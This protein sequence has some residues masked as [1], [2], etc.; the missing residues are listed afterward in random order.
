MDTVDALNRGEM[1]VP[2]RV[3]IRPS[4]Y[5]EMDVLKYYSLPNDQESL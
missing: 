5:E 2:G 4:R 3:G 1:I